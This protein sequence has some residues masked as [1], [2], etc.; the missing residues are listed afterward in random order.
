[1]ECL[2]KKSMTELDTMLIARYKLLAN[3]RVYDSE[4]LKQEIKQIQAEMNTKRQEA[5]ELQWTR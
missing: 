3:S 4:K 1:M 2:S 5:K